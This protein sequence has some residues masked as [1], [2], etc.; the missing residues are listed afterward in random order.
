M[1]FCDLAERAGNLSVEQT[2]LRGKSSLQINEGDIL[3]GGTN[4]RERGS[5]KAG[6]NVVIE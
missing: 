5:R 3:G 1:R 4:H 6:D 2:L